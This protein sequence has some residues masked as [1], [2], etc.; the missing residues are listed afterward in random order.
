MAKSSIYDIFKVKPKTEPVHFTSI[1]TG[2]FI[3]FIYYKAYEYLDGLRS[4]SCA[5]KELSTLKNLEMFFIILTVF[6]TLVNLLKFV[7]NKTLL[8]PAGSD[9]IIMAIYLFF[10]L[11]IELV[12]I[13]N[14]YT[15]IYST[16]GCACM[17]HW[18]K[19][20]LYIQSIMYSLV[21]ILG[22]ILLL[23][24]GFGPALL[25]LIIISSLTYYAIDQM[26]K[27]GEPK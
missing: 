7:S 15:Y 1:L 21:P 12:Y 6:F 27:S 11:A 5:P 22:V 10:L 14:V 17:D 25:F 24:F 26:S 13:Y 20:I 16:N 4:C 19:Y 18:Q 9:F 8:I 23:L 3:I 2:V